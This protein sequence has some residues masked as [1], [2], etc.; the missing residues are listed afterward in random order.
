MKHS[1]LCK[2]KSWGGGGGY[3]L[4]VMAP[5]D[6]GFLAIL[7]WNKVFILATLAW[8]RV[9]FLCKMGQIEGPTWLLWFIFDPT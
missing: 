1:G 7:A 4:F 5:R 3:S 2:G 6:K 9:L 8:E